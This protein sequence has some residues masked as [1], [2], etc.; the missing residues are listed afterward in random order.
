[1]DI[2]PRNKMKE[3]HFYKIFLFLFAG[4][5]I[6][7]IFEVLNIKGYVQLG[8]ED[9]GLLSVPSMMFILS[10]FTLLV[11]PF[12]F[13]YKAFRFEIMYSFAITVAAP[14]G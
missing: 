14:F 8:P 9:Y 11:N 6:T 5:L 10:V 3:H 2:H 7:G 4:L 13:W 1:M 12:D